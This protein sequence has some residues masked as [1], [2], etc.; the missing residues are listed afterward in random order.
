MVK[1]ET[2]PLKQNNTLTL[3]R[4]GGTFIGPINAT[5]IISGKYGKSMMRN[6][7]KVQSIN[8]KGQLFVYHTLPEITS[9]SPNDGG[10]NGK[11]HLK[12][13]GNSFDS[14]PG[15]TKVKVGDQ[16]C[17]IVDITSSE[18]TCLTPKKED[19]NSV[20]GGPRGLLYE[21]WVNTEAEFTAETE[22]TLSTTSNDYRKMV[23]DN[24]TMQGK[25]F[26]DQIKGFTARMSGLFVAPY[27]GK[28]AFYLQCSSKC[29][30]NWSNST[31]PTVTESLLYWKNGQ[32]VKKLGDGGSR[33]RAI[34]VIKGDEYYIEALQTQ[35]ADD[36]D[37]NLL[38]ISL[39]E[40]ET[41]YHHS[42][43]KNIRDER[44]TFKLAYARLLETQRITVNGVSGVD[45]V[46]FT[47]SGKE[48]TE[49]FPLAVED[50][51][52]TWEG[53]FKKMLIKKCN[54]IRGTTLYLNDYENTNYHLS[55]AGGNMIT[56][57]V[58]FCG[59]RVL[60]KQNR[61]MHRYGKS[62]IDANRYKYLCFAVKGK[63]LIGTLQLNVQWQ[64]FD[65]RIFSSWIYL[66]NMWEP[67]NEWQYKCWNWDALIRNTTL[68]GLTKMKE[69]STHIKI[70]DIQTPVENSQDYWYFDEFSITEEE[71][72]LT[73]D[74]GAV[75]SEEV[76]VQGVEVNF[77]EDTSSFDV[78][79]T[80]KTCN[81]A[82]DDFAL[83]GIKDAVI[84]GLD[85]TGISDPGDKELA[86]Q[87]YL[88]T[89]DNVTY[90][91]AAWG[92]GTIT[93]SRQTRGSR[94]LSGRLTLSHK[95]KTTSYLSPD[96]KAFELRHVLENQLGLTGV[97]PYYWGRDCWDLTIPYD[98]SQA[99]LGGDV[100]TVLMDSSEL[101]VDNNN[102]WTFLANVANIDGGAF[103]QA[104]GGDFFKLR[105]EDQHVTVY[106]NDFLASCTSDCKNMGAICTKECLFQY[107]DDITP[108]LSSVSS[109]T[110]ANRQK[111][112]TILGE[113]FSIVS[114]DYEIY[115]GE[116][117]CA[118]TSSTTTEVK[119]IIG[120]G[121]AGLYD[122][123]FIVK[124]RGEATPPLSGNL[125]YEVQLSISSSSP[126]RGSTGGG[127]VLVVTG[128]G[129]PSS[130][131][132][133][134]GNT[135]TVAGQSC[136]VIESMSNEVKCM[137][138][139]GTDELSGKIEI[140]V[141]SLSANNGTFTYDS[142]LSPKLSSINP[143]T[144]TPIGGGTLT[145]VG[146][147]FGA[148]WGSVNI[149]EAKCDIV[150]WIDTLIT[151]TIP[152]NNNGEHRVKVDVPNKGFANNEGVQAFVVNFKV[153]NI[154]PKVGSTLGGTTVK[155]SGVGFGDCT[156]VEIKMGAQFECIIE[157]CTN[158]E[159]FCKT[160][161]IQNT[162]IVDN[163]GKHPKYG[164]GYVWNPQEIKVLPGDSVQWR[165]SIISKAEEVG[166][167]VFQTDG[168]LDAYDGSGF[169]S[170]KKRTSGV[171]TES[172][173]TP[174]VFHY[175]GDPV[176]INEPIMRGKVIVE[177]FKE[178]TTL[179]LSVLMS[180]IEAFHD[181]SSAT[182]EVLGT[183]DG[184]QLTETFDCVSEPIITDVFE[185]TAA[186]CL[187]PKITDLQLTNI[188]LNEAKPNWILDNA[189]V[190]LTGEGFST[191]SCQNQIKLGKEHSCSITSVTTTSIECN[192]LLNVNEQQYL[193][194]LKL[195]EVNLNVMNKGFALLSLNK[196]EM[197]RLMLY[198]VVNSINIEEGSWAGGNIL[199][200]TG[201][202]LHPDGGKKTVQVIFG[203]EGFQAS[204]TI[205]EVSYTDISCLIPD[206]RTFKGVDID[207]TVPVTVLIGYDQY[208]P[209]AN[210]ALNYTFKNALVSTADSISASTVTSGTVLTI[211]GTNFGNSVQNVKIFAKLPG[212]S[213][214]RKRSIPVIDAVEENLPTPEDKWKKLGVKTWRCGK[215]FC[216]NEE[217]TKNVA[218]NEP[219]IR[220]TK[221]SLFSE[222]Q[223]S[224][225]DDERQTNE[226]CKEFPN[227]CW[228]RILK[229]KGKKHSRNRRSTVQEL[230]EMSPLAENSFEADVTS[231]SVNSIQLTFPN[232][233][234]GEYDIIVNIEGSTGNSV[235]NFG[236][237][238]SEMSISS[239]TPGSGSIH[240]GHL[241]TIS[242]SGFSGN[243]NN[244][245]VTI[246]TS[247]CH[248]AESSPSIIKCKTE[249][250]TAE[251]GTL[252]VISNE[253]TSIST[254]Y[255]QDSA[256]TPTINSVSTPS[257]NKITISGSNFGS[258]PTAFIGKYECVSD[259]ASDTE[260]I[261]TV[262]SIPGGDY[263]VLINNPD[264]GISNEDKVLNVDLMI[265]GAS[266]S[267]GSFGGGTELTITG[268]G[269]DIPENVVLTICENSCNILSSSTTELK[270]LAPSNSGSES[271]LACDIILTQEAGTI[272]KS[273]LFSYDSSMTPVIQSVSPNR[274]GTGG[275]TLLTI[276]GSGFSENSNMVTIDESK[277]VVVTQT[278]TE[279][280]CSTNH[281]NG[282]VKTNVIVDIPGKGHAKYQDAESGEFY[283]I[284]RWS[285]KWTWGGTGTPLE[286]EFIVITPGMTI[287][288][289]TNTPVLK[290]LL[291]NG[292]TLIFDEEQA[293]IELQAEYILI[294]GGGSLQVGTE[295]KP[296]QS[297]AVITMH[298]HVRCVEMPVFGCKVI[299]VREGSLD[300]HGKY[301]P[302]TWTHLAST[303]EPGENSL[304]LKQPVTWKEGDHI[305]IAT[306]GD[307][308]SMKENEE[309]YIDAISEDGLT[310]TLKNPL[311]YRHISIEQTFGERTVETRGEVALLTRNVLVRGT[312]NEQ[313]S[314]VIPACE[315]EF[316]SG[317]AFSDAMQTCFAGKFGEEI[318]TDEMGAVIIISPKYKD[319]GLVSARFSYV[320]LT[321]VGQAFRV[322]RYPIH[323]H[324]PGIQNTSYI[325][326]IAVHHSNNRACTLHDVSNLVIEHNVAYNIKGLTFF[327]EDGVEMYNTI[328]YNLAIFTR[329]SNSLLNPDINPASFWI[330]NPF[331]KFRHNACAGGTHHCFWLR[332]AS[333]PDGPSWVRKFCPYKVPFDE[334]H[335][336]TAHSMGW[337]GFWIFGQSNH[338]SYDPHTGTL[339]KGYCNGYRTQARLGSF[340]TWNNKRGFEIVS[341]A[342]IRLENQ[343]HMDHDFSAYEIFKAKGPGGPGGAGIFNSLIVGHSEVS[344]LT[345]KQDKVTPAGIHLPPQGYTLE[346]ISFYNF[347]AGEAGYALGLRFEEPG[348]STLPIRV[349]GLKFFQTT[350]RQFTKAKQLQG[351]HYRDV[352]GSL[353][354]TSGSQLVSKSGTNP[355]V[356]VDD[357]SGFLGGG[358]PS[359]ICDES[360]TFHRVTIEKPEPSSLL[361]NKVVASNQYGTSERVWMDM[362]EGWQALLPQGPVNKI[363]FDTAEHLTNISYVISGYGMHE[364]ENYIIL[365]HDLNQQPDRF[366]I[367]DDK[368]TNSSAS[369]LNPP[370]FDTTENGDWY[371]NNETGTA[372]HEML[373]ILS[374]KGTGRKNNWKKRSI[375]ETKKTGDE[376]VWPVNDVST[377]TFSVIRCESEGC[378]PIPP[379]TMDPTRPESFI[380]WSD[381]ENWLDANLS[382]P[383]GRDEVIIP[384][385]AWVV[386]DE[387]PPKFKRLYVYG[388]LEVP[389]TEDRRLEVEILLIMGGR[390]MVG[391]ETT[392]FEHNFEL[393][394]H[395]DHY[396]TDQ[397]M[398]NAPN[399]GAK[400]LG[401][402]GDSIR[403][404]VYPGLL[405]M[406]GKDVGKSWVKLAATVEKGASVLTVEEDITWK[407]GDKI[408]ITAT[409]YEPLETEK[410]TIQSINGRVLTLDSP[411]DYDHLSVEE[412]LSNTKTY[413]LQA[414]VGLLTRNVKIIGATYDD[415]D[416]EMFGARVIAAAF[417]E[418]SLI[419]PGYARFSNV[420]FLRVGQEGWSDNFDPRYSLAF[421][422][423]Y[424]EE[425]DL[426]PLGE[427]NSFVKKCAFDYNYNSAIGIFKSTDVV[428]ENNVIYRHIN[429]GIFDESKGSKI[430]GNLV[431]MGESINEIKDLEFAF[432]FLGCINIIRGTETVLQN[433]VMAGC[434]QGGL[435]TRGNPC[436]TEYVWT[437]N[438]I[439]STIHAVHLNNR[440]LDKLGCVNIKNIFA[441]RNF[442]Y[443]LMAL[444]SDDV[445]IEDFFLV[446]NGVGVMTHLVGPSAVKHEIDDGRHVSLSKSTIV[447]NSAAFECGNDDA[448]R[449]LDFSPEKKRGWTQKKKGYAHTAV[450]FPIFQSSFVK[451]TLQWHQGLVSAE[452][453][454]PALRGIMYMDQVTFA[455]FDGRCTGKKDTVFRTN[456]AADDMNW[457]IRTTKLVFVDVNEESKVLYDRP[458]ASKIN[459]ADCTD[460]DC[461]G[462]K[463]ALIEDKDGTLI[464]N[465]GGTIIPDSAYEWDGNPRRGLGYYRIPKPMITEL[466]GDRIPYDT[467]MPNTG[468]FR[469]GQCTWIE[470]WTAYKCHNIEHK[471]MIIESMDRDSRIRRLSPIAVL[472]N[473]GSGGY[474]DL[475]NGP[476]DISCCQGYTCAERL[477]TFYT[478]V[479]TGQEHEIF[480]T[481]TPPQNF[482]F[483]LLHNEDESPVRIKM[484]FPKQQRLDVYTNGEFIAPNNKDFAVVDSL[485]LKKPDP[486]F[487]PPMSDLHCSNYFDPNTGHLYL[488]IKEKSTCDIKTQPVV[489][490]KLGILVRE[491]D[492]FDEAQIIQNIA[493]LIGIP[494]HK[495]RVTNIV[496]EGSSRRKRET[497]ETP[498][499]ELQIVENP[500]LTLGEDFSEPLPTY[501]TPAN[502]NDP[503]QNPLY[504]TTPGTTTTTEDFTVTVP[505]IKLDYEALS[506]IE[507][508]MATALQTGELASVLGV[509]VTAMEVSKPI[510]PPE[511]EPAY[512]SPE[513]R[514]V[515][516]DKTFAETTLEADTAKLEELTKED[517]VKV[518]SKLVLA[519]N[520]YDPLE[521]T[522]ME[523]YPYLFLEAAD[524]EQLSVV[525]GPGDPWIVTATLVS[526]P[527]GAT[528][529]GAATASFVNGFVNFTGLLLSNKG[530]GYSVKFE[531]TYPDNLNIPSVTS[532]QFIT[533]PRP[534]GLVIENIE[535]QVPEAEIAAV[536]FSIYDLGLQQ[537]A[538]PE[539][540]GALTWECSLG[541]SI[542]TPVG[543]EGN[544]S[545]SIT[546]GTFF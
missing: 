542:N 23:L 343:T 305:A 302:V 80:P 255:T 433:N 489:V 504:T 457:P 362:F 218:N 144:S 132:G 396:T 356:C 530:S 3:I 242:G 111:E 236:T 200:I 100:D 195:N 292:G 499:I 110:D 521:M 248:I 500:V 252:T 272:T 459:P 277:C 406:H 134:T 163:G 63:T 54:I 314:E 498:G 220:R 158:T 51:K 438:E 43:T 284:D 371:F 511:E 439:H 171:Y 327:L 12:I 105:V 320:E 353:T 131:E 471:L 514:A 198:P 121:P 138:V 120:S 427:L 477:S 261:C 467:K 334:F 16:D 22:V 386:L 456:A 36:Q 90:S 296:Y 9:V 76:Q 149:G 125:K 222:I 389:D 455:N 436:G 77:I 232:L 156:D 181:T 265:S 469:D 192:L 297:N 308:N 19:V 540:I 359:A 216:N 95:N 434:V 259:Q 2:V 136:S 17:E 15:K 231:V 431:A 98:F 118:V 109:S 479:A 518:P 97:K 104:P 116:H 271:I 238:Q 501:T 363:T 240:G 340:T 545:T 330:V 166:I 165:W 519:R 376:G 444:S 196:M 503:T 34:E 279:I 228:A 397:P 103:I 263:P 488:L 368:E 153:T 410:R 351:I 164:A 260:V 214:R 175:A 101:L 450:I 160:K 333:V 402:Y 535:D 287:L 133:W 441:W 447:G 532:R 509:E 335:N 429:N 32:V 83:F 300:L 413:K 405:D 170:G 486:S 74:Y 189:Q 531:L 474:I 485:Q 122:I 357:T 435:L 237:L 60:E 75:P 56:Q 400:A 437:G 470:G 70:E 187:T 99:S 88:K 29:R 311:K 494:A 321:S 339:E 58:P 135:I 516:L 523:I 481:S 269:F 141:N 251:C 497:S 318:G 454:N 257:L 37:E 5:I 393:Y 398:Y 262:P 324:L 294:V 492:F 432:V 286:E 355:P 117:A 418:G 482:R 338:V 235:V 146:S 59:E 39:W 26:E 179:E 129:F 528:I 270:C 328:Q 416:E 207:K 227:E 93:I 452:G 310:I 502:P 390:L 35:A 210:V 490:L 303:V 194:S 527:S 233:P 289:D 312:V 123:S 183:I 366:K 7:D 367:V 152:K 541:W 381:P 244:T 203:E 31:D 44:Q 268:S 378:I 114:D 57:G 364:G 422:N 430:V 78:V 191:V 126:E 82:K 520:I 172:F 247:T 221:R 108:S 167:N 47:Q 27:T 209:K 315:E 365:G 473:S 258:S 55:G 313:F 380:T 522:P 307:R 524:G 407:A 360:V 151:C 421:V 462:M 150:S 18:L 543:I 140:T 102:G 445:E 461:D 478:M 81:E 188:G 372:T 266:P 45:E 331:N 49:A 155:I 529:E 38:Q 274:G 85:L 394:L 348:E 112:L 451:I 52:S 33:S 458:L 204:C 137:T 139:E 513:E 526:G 79:I 417:E 546:Q 408:V 508:K 392:P 466:N 395:G 404:S 267:K 176:R 350:Q 487:I 517:S 206:Y 119:C 361:F 510:P 304:T 525:G 245:V 281:H 184:C 190:T 241:I 41:V 28:V 337:Y 91:N 212:Q 325:R 414:E 464:G 283:Y 13:Q 6:S 65:D 67:S 425:F 205:I 278:P 213:K 375:V 387:N 225:E 358:V 124:S 68:S 472:T 373:Y 443:G 539:V 295:E 369:L 391:E 224:A 197:S 446:E 253:M 326:G 128:E 354:G 385:G 256:T 199:R 193:D 94:A 352:D 185:F 347:D 230:I 483:H 507:S 512:T 309:N 168:V 411:L 336:N 332:P 89:N 42:Q 424:P 316:S 342:N 317:G 442:D 384:R 96:I 92:G 379:P 537:K 24:S 264:F 73:F 377:G 428:V 173:I 403:T 412:Q 484:W 229:T 409:N 21:A 544:K 280:T 290:F 20:A 127:T 25:A 1:K 401:V 87:N 480:M 178:D 440:G 239:V 329:M 276:S 491:E 46:I 243:V 246:G 159:I 275:G 306:T 254:S 534:L 468:I 301:I 86:V 323:F 475:V 465:G 536:K 215:G 182:T 106:V 493:G 226:I 344:D 319:Q 211:S 69:G 147:A 420:E 48:A 154:S 72:D 299:G 30:L 148:T 66:E 50:S 538:T 84:T 448:P 208:P 201:T 64:R 219:T 8:S 53:K 174:G 234:A 115:V 453:S 341:G 285:S 177:G 322:G 62:K 273:G 250:C 505:E 419:K 202:G 143:A 382:T 107:K 463:K 415:Q 40:Y 515:V 349:S 282:A 383:T 423:S 345:G 142:S 11:T 157:T 10:N 217:V 161:L 374:S 533:G 346:N 14:Y 293:D 130:I 288:L 169:I 186:V 145:L 449:I 426:L 180:G 506:K 4:P 162:H 399:L 298:G 495:I 249:P 388:T 113:N 61:L 223:E 496:R 291:I 370:T 476:Q 71:V 460:F